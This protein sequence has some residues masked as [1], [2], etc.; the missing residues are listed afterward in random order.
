M[1]LICNQQPFTA[2]IENNTDGAPF[3]Y[4]PKKQVTPRKYLIK[5]KKQILMRFITVRF[6]GNLKVL[7]LM[8]DNMERKWLRRLGSNLTKIQR[9]VESFAGPDAEEK[10]E[11]VKDEKEQ[12]VVIDHFLIKDTSVLLSMTMLKYN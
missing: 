4:F 7:L 1:A 9:H 2:R 3:F 6:C 12:K 5:L 10:E 8:D 11:E